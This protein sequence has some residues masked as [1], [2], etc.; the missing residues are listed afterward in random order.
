MT[1]RPAIFTEAQIRRAIRAAKAEGWHR[2]EI[3]DP[4]TGTRLVCE[5]A[6]AKPERQL[7]ELEI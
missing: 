7:E 4:K 3:V 1:K 6:A 5:G 2:V